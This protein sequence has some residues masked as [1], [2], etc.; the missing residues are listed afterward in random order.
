MSKFLGFAVL[1][2]L[3]FASVP[4]CLTEAGQAFWFVAGLGCLV[5]AVATGTE[6]VLTRKP[7]A[8]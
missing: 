6:A 2:V 1:C 5:G 4:L 3:A 7:V 8:K